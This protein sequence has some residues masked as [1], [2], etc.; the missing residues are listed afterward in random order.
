MLYQ[1]LYSPIIFKNFLGIVLQIFLYLA[2]FKYNTTVRF[3]QSEVVLYLN[4]RTLGEE[5]KDY[6][7]ECSVN[8]DP[9]I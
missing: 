7:W 1:G 5:D 2:A 4:V 9:V 6:S 8:T 3:I